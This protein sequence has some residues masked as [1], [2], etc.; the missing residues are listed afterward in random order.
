MPVV[1]DEVILE[2]VDD[3]TETSER[4]PMAQQTPLAPSEL[5]LVQ[6]LDAIR[7]RQERLMID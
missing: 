2:A 6:L 3:V 1:I 4:Q 5:E 7:Q